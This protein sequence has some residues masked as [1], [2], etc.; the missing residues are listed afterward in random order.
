V[1]GQ[2][3]VILGQSRRL[4]IFGGEVGE[5]VVEQVELNHLLQQTEVERLAVEARSRRVVRLRLEESSGRLTLPCESYV[6]RVARRVACR[7]YPISIH[8]GRSE[9]GLVS[10]AK[11][12]GLTDEKATVR[13]RLRRVRQLTPIARGDADRYRLDGRIQVRRTDSRSVVA[14]GGGYVGTGTLTAEEERRR[15][16]A[17]SERSSKRERREEHAKI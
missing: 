3:S 4:P 8:S 1:L 15:G 10:M 6:G 14:R 9:G 7:M 17:S 16:R 2:S 13:V 12:P 11:E 5:Q